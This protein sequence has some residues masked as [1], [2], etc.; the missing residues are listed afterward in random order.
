MLN[1]L[2]KLLGGEPFDYAH[3]SLTARTKPRDGC[4][5][6]RRWNRRR[7]DRQQRAA[8]RKQRTAPTLGEKAEVANARE[9]LGENMLQEPPQELFVRKRHGAAL[10]VVRI[11]LPAKRDVVSVTSTRRWLEMATRCV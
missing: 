6:G 7:F 2:A 3:R 9:A 5:C 8:E 10:A 4:S 11:V 1:L